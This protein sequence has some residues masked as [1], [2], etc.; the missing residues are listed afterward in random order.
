MVS[1]RDAALGFDSGSCACAGSAVAHAA[2][3]ASAIEPLRSLFVSV[4]MDRSSVRV[5]KAE[6]LFRPAASSP[7]PAVAPVTE[8][9]QAEEES[10]RIVAGAGECRT[11]HG[12]GSG[13]SR[14]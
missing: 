12:A 4:F 2:T 7:H 1:W 9:R 5:M 3:I 11:Q 8:M 10:W 14:R 6:Q 13:G